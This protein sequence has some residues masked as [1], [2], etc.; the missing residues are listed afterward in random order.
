[1]LISPFNAAF[2][3]LQ[4]LFFLGSDV[5]ALTRGRS[6][7]AAFVTA[8]GVVHPLRRLCPGRTV[9]E[10]GSRLNLAEARRILRAELARHAAI[11]CSD[12]LRF[13]VEQ[14]LP[15][16]CKRDW[17]E[18][19]RLDVP[20]EQQPPATELAEQLDAF[21]RAMPTP[22]TPSPSYWVFG[23]VWLLR[24][25]AAVAGR[26]H[27]LWEGSTLGISGDYSLARTLESQWFA[28]VQ[29]F[30]SESA[31]RLADRM[32]GLKDSA[33]LVAARDELDRN[34][35]FQRGDL[36]F[37]AGDPPR[38]GHVLPPHYNRVLGRESRRDL[39]MTAALTFPPTIGVPAVYHSTAPG[40]WRLFT[41]PHGLCLGGGPP[42]DRPEMPGVALMAYLRWAALRIAANGVFHANDDA[43]TDV[44][45]G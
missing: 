19:A 26:E 2:H 5:F 1:V 12:G 20:A 15:T 30:A 35:S 3:G 39:A 44:Y 40:R 37:L 28:R 27:V 43:Q 29:A 8:Q 25:A 16:F 42:G 13:F 7:S 33:A 22:E 4:P 10:H 11:G 6:D 24:P 17:S 38:I 36:L 31:R 34:G 21:A 14:L 45:D 32:P 18:D 41:L 23:R 9:V